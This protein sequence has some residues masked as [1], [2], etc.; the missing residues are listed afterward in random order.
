[1]CMFMFVNKWT[2]SN[3]KL[4]ILVLAQQLHDYY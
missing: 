1:M 2:D 3:H 4:D